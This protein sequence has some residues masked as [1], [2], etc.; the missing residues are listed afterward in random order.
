MKVEPRTGTPAR[1]FETFIGMT[2]KSV[3]QAQKE[4]ILSFEQ[5]STDPVLVEGERIP[6]HRLRQAHLI[7]QPE[8]NLVTPPNGDQPFIHLTGMKYEIGIGPLTILSD[9][10]ELS[11]DAA[12]I[13]G[14]QVMQARH[15][16]RNHVFGLQF[17]AEYVLSITLAG[18]SVLYTKS[19]SVGFRKPL[20]TQ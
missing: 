12:E 19:L 16:S 15:D 10:L 14:K 20:V 6:G 3:R 13:I 2:L 4:L 1:N 9:Y 7:C 11:G 8:G 5:H 17:G 18:L